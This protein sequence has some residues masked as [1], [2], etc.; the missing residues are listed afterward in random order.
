[1]TVGAMFIEKMYLDYLNVRGDLHH[2]IDTFPCLS[3]YIV[4]WTKMVKLKL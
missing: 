4:N 2:D 3:T 1:L